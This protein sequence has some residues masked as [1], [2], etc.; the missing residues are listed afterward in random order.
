ML[1]F[2]PRGKGGTATDGG[3]VI[4][5]EKN[6]RSTYNFFLKYKDDPEGLQAYLNQLV[7][8]RG[9]VRRPEGG[10]IF[11]REA[12]NVR[13]KDTI[14]GQ[15]VI[16]HKKIN[17][18]LNLLMIFMIILFIMNYHMESFQKRGESKAS[19]KRIDDEAIKRLLQE[20]IL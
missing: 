7:P 9:T 2:Q 20:K 19:R 14:A 8:E 4:I 1:F 6:I 5:N 3:M 11:F 17:N 12:K 13:V 16:M 10:E 18:I 15:H